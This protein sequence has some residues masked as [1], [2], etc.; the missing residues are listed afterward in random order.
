MVCLFKATVGGFDQLPL[1][2]RG[3][4]GVL[5]ALKGSGEALKMAMNWGPILT[6]TILRNDGPSKAASRFDFK[7][8][9]SKMYA[10]NEVPTY[11]KYMA[12]SFS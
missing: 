5:V 2:F 11:K 10:G 3:C 1:G 9:E 7:S 6:S 8:E 4:L 12:R